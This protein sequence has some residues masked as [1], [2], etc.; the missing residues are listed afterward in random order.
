MM[1]ARCQYSSLS[2]L[3]QKGRKRHRGEGSGSGF[4]WWAE[5]VCG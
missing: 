4:D 1:E 3:P 2:G 5:I